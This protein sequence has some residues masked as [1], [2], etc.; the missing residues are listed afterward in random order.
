MH[1]VQYC[2]IQGMCVSCEEKG[3]RPH[4]FMTLKNNDVNHQVIIN[5]HSTDDT[6]IYFAQKKSIQHTL[7]DAT[8]PHIFTEEES[9]VFGIDYCRTNI[10]DGVQFIQYSLEDMEKKLQNIFQEIS[11]QPNYIVHAYGSI[12]SFTDHNNVNHTNVH[13]THMNQG[14]PSEQENYQYND[15]AILIQNIHTNE[16]EGLFFHFGNQKCEQC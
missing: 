16:V 15:G 5:I 1:K 4:F 3:E 8:T 10:L 7:Y 6:N 11:N 12:I 14:Y 13:K 9:K 2:V